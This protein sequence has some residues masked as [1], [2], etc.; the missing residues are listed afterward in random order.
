MLIK[1]LRDPHDEG[2]VSNSRTDP[3][4]IRKKAIPMMMIITAKGFRDYP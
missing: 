3:A 2:G 4:K 1:I